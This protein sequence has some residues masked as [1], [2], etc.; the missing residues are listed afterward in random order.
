MIDPCF[1]EKWWVQ[2]GEVGR[3]S[4]A[5]LAVWFGGEGLWR[6]IRGESNRASVWAGVDILGLVVT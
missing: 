6:Q 3:G 2:K 1:L 4:W 5:G